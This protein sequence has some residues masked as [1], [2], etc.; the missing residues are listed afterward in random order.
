PGGPWKPDGRTP[1]FMLPP[2]E[3]PLE[4]RSRR[5]RHPPV[6]RPRQPGLTRTHHQS[7]LAAKVVGGE[8]RRLPD[9]TTFGGWAAPPTPAAPIRRP[10]PKSNCGHSVF[11]GA[12]LTPGRPAHARQARLRV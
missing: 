4:P 8:E 7:A 6:Q 9:H 3:T 12:E 1:R 2:Q 5:A 10:S 11:G